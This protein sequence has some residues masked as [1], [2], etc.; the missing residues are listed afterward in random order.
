MNR[1]SRQLVTFV[2]ALLITIASA[3]GA[4]AECSFLIEVQGTISGSSI[5]C[6][7][8]GEDAQYCYYDCVCEGSQVI[9]DQLY[10]E[11]GLLPD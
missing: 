4:A 6:E 7:L 11:N 5:S 9:C 3:I 10:R 2:F 1:L 8:T